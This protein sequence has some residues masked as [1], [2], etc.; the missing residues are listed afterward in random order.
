MITGIYGDLGEGKTL[1]MTRCLYLKYLLGNDIY[2]N[3]K[4]SFPSTPIDKNFLKD[5]VT[6][7]KDLSGKAVFGLDELDMYVNSRR[8]ASDNNLLISYLVKQIRKK[9][10]EIFYTTQN[11]RRVDIN[12]RDLTRFKILCKSQ[13]VKIDYPDGKYILKFIVATKYKE[14]K[15]IWTKRF[16]ANKYFNMYDTK[17]LIVYED[18]R[19]EKR[20]N[21]EKR[22][23]E[24]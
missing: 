8:S 19:V 13:T 5:L 12:I 2:S 22:L 7:K 21:K 15:K 11:F 9:N 16:L 20:I 17:E 3:Y 14:D 1:F 10:I 6:G 18:D 4:L 23:L 24:K